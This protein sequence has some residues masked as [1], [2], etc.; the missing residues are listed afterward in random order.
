MIILVTALVKKDK[1][2]MF[3]Y[4]HIPFRH[5]YQELIVKPVS[6]ELLTLE[7][8]TW[9]LT[10]LQGILNNECTCIFKTLLKSIPP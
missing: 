2:N 3:V 9:H 8:R 5:I 4:F 7:H 10:R 6:G 1:K